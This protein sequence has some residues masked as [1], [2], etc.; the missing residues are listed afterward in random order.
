MHPPPFSNF[1]VFL[2]LPEVLLDVL[3]AMLNFTIVYLLT[4]PLELSKIVT[5]LFLKLP[6]VDLS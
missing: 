4:I 2:E 1:S 6:K 5:T 3:L